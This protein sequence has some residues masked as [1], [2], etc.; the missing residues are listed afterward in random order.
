MVVSQHNYST[1]MTW[2][3]VGSWNYDTSTSLVKD[4]WQQTWIFSCE[5]ITLWHSHLWWTRKSKSSIKVEND[6]SLQ[7]SPRTKKLELMSTFYHVMRI[8][9]AKWAKKVKPLICE[10]QTNELLSISWDVGPTFDH[11]LPSNFGFI[12]HPSPHALSLGLV[13]FGFTTVVFG[14]SLI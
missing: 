6:T 9:V 4:G 8:V 14:A 1:R 7:I 2:A 12:P 13:P 11:F 5:I 3:R 10:L